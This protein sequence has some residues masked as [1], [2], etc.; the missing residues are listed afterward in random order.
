MKFTTSLRS[1]SFLRAAPLVL[2]LTVVYYVA[3]ESRPL[4]TYHGFAP[5]LVA[6]PLMELYAL[7]YATAAGLASWES[8]RLVSGGVWSLVPARS[9]FRIAAN[10]LLPVVLLA[11]LVLL[12]PAA[13]SL[14]RTGTLPTADSLRLPAMACILCLAHAV[15]GFSIGLRVH[16]IIAVPIVTVGTWVLVAFSRAVQ[17]YWLRH[18]SG[19]F[20]DLSFGQVP[21][22]A[23]LVAPLLFG[24][25]IAAGIAV[26]WVPIRIRAVR[27]VIALAVTAAGTFGGYHIASNWHHD[28]PLLTGRAPMTCEGTAPEVCMPQGVGP[29][30]ATVRREAVSV[31]SALQGKG[32]IRVPALITDRLL[33]DRIARPS[34]EGSLRVDL[35][36]AAENGS[37]RFA[38]LTAAVRFPCTEVDLVNGHAALLWGAT[39]T[40]QVSAYERRVS[41]EQQSSQTRAAEAKVHSI[42]A[43]VLTRSDREQGAWFRQTRDAACGTTAGTSGSDNQPAVRQGGR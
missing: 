15:I 31:V 21:A 8:G 10:A 3:G 29:D 23:S 18:I 6:A 28:P 11:W 24:C 30:L 25:G 9:R 42:V 5:A 27:A 35:T 34:T 36:S 7:A 13:V 14:G 22:V 1:G 33:D 41:Q 40:G 2:L 26:L 16:R 37:V 39:V 19:Q 20:M 12:L 43:T 17:P 32:A 4:S 38:V